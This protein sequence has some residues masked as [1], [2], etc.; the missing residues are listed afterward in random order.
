MCSAEKKF[1]ITENGPVPSTST[2]AAEASH[3]A[4]YYVFREESQYIRLFIFNDGLH[5]LPHFDFGKCK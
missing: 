5:Y 3:S 2:A 4:R 1:G